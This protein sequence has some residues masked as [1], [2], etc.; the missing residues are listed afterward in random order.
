MTSYVES[1][2][3]KSTRYCSRPGM[4]IAGVFVESRASIFHDDPVHR[5]YPYR[6][7]PKRQLGNGAMTVLACVTRIVLVY[8]VL[9]V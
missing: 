1:G 4:S 8:A 3:L 9:G 6:A 2:M 5:A 7:V